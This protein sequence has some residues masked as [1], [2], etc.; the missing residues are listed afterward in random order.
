MDFAKAVLFSIGKDAASTSSKRS[1]ASTACMQTSARKIWRSRH[2]TNFIIGCA[3]TPHQRVGRT[4]SL[5]INQISSIALYS[6]AVFSEKK[7]QMIYNS[8]AS[9][10]CGHRPAQ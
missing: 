2:G 7:Y 4:A 5:E 3:K 9:S 10:S 6:T 1:I 8:G